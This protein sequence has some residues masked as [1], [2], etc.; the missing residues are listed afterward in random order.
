[1]L[2]TATPLAGLVVVE[3]EPHA[4]GRGFFARMVC[5]DE[6]RERGLNANFVQQSLSYNA[7]KGIV[8]GLH[9]QA[10]PHGEDKLIRVTR[11]GIFD[12]TVDLRPDSPTFRRWFGLELSSG[13]RR[14][15][16]V[17][18]GFA[19]GFQTLTDQAEVFYQMTA[20]HCPEA[21]RGARWNDPAFAIAWPDPAGA[22]LSGRDGGYADFTLET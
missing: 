6:F 10:E 7:R 22:E 14:A 2:F 4:D 17:P 19:H 8:R 15:I 5:R 21:A 12:V 20:P 13:N 9:Y 3:P 18:R 11:G 1:M 16:Y